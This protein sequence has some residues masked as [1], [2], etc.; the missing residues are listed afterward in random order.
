ME[1]M[2]AI[3][4]GIPDMLRVNEHQILYEIELSADGTHFDM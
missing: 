1:L 2:Q 4:Y 3:K